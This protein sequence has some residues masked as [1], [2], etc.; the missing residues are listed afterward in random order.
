MTTDSPEGMTLGSPEVMIP[1]N[2]EV[3]IP[4]NPEEMIIGRLEWMNLTTEDRTIGTKLYRYIFLL[5]N[6]IICTIY[7]TKMKWISLEMY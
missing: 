1:D 6:Y 4:D 3:M 2:P 5:I 7:H